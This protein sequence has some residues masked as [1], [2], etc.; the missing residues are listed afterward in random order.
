MCWNTD[1]SDIVIRCVNR[2]KT[3]WSGSEAQKA[4]VENVGVKC[5]G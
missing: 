5:H 3:I 1:D 4:I 2:R